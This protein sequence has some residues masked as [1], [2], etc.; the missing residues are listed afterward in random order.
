M[1]TSCMGLDDLSD[2]FLSSLGDY[3]KESRVERRDIGLCFISSGMGTVAL[4][5]AIWVNDRTLRLWVEAFNRDGVSSLAYD[6]YHG[7]KRH[8]SPAPKRRSWS[9]LLGK[10]FRRNRGW[11]FGAGGLWGGGS[12]IRSG[13]SIANRACI[14]FFIFL[15]HAE[16]YSSGKRPCA[17]RR[18]QKNRFPAWST[19]WFVPI[20]MPA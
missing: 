9:R 7:G 4:A 2:T 19:E 15:A 13:W 12:R 17:L 3:R 10:G 5:K 6:R 8:L 11:K 14:S 20:A 1:R 18:V 16:T